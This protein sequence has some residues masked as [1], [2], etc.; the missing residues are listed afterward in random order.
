MGRDISEGHPIGVSYSLRPRSANGRSQSKRMVPAW[1]LNQRIRL[2]G[3]KVGCG[4]CHSNYAQ[5]QSNL[6]MPNDHGQLCR[7]CHQ[8]R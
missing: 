2:F 4:S 6:V 1:A 7:S 5:Y 8:G 3:G